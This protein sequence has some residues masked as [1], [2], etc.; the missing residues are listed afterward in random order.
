M[1]FKSAL[2]WHKNRIIDPWNR[3]QSLEINSSIFAPSVYNEVAKNMQGKMTIFQQ[4]LKEKLDSHMQR[5]ENGSIYHTQKLT[6]NELKTW[7]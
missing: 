6:Q 2:Y 4:M 1:L 7:I 5:D 3:I